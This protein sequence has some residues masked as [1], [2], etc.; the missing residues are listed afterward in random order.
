VEYFRVRRCE[1]GRNRVTL[2]N[3]TF[4]SD[5]SHWLFVLRMMRKQVE[6]LVE[7]Y[8]VEQG[9]LPC[10]LGLA[11]ARPLTQTEVC[12]LLRPPN[13]PNPPWPS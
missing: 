8:K 9:N 3:V 12:G 7:Q 5:V 13:P 11:C 2:D 6:T 1:V 10:R 4:F